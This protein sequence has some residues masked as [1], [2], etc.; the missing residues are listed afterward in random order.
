MSVNEPRCSALSRRQFL[1]LAGS[2][3]GLSLLAACAPTPPSSTAAPAKPTEPAK[4]AAP[5]PG[6]PAAPAASPAAAPGAKPAE[7]PAA[8]APAVTTSAPQW[9]VALTE[10]PTSFDAAVSTYTFSNVMVETH[11]LQNLVDVQGQELK[12]TPILA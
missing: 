5:A 11:I 3:A 6:A 1:R 2:A 10:E 12:V 4:P 8:A 7:S 9:T